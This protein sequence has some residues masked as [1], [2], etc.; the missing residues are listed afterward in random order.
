MKRRHTENP[1]D[2]FSCGWE[3]CQYIPT[4]LT[5]LSEQVHL[6]DLRKF[7]CPAKGIYSLKLVDIDSA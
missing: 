2:V 7:P 4:R 6:L 5:T 3:G 1:H